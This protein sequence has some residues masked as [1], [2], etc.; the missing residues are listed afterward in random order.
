MYF[1]DLHNDTHIWGCHKTDWQGVLDSPSLLNAEEQKKS[2]HYLY[3]DDQK[4]YRIGRHLLRSKAAEYL[5]T[6]ARKIVICNDNNGK[7]Y[8][9]DF[10]DVFFSLS[11][12]G[13]WVMVAISKRRIGIDVQEHYITDI[14]KI[15]NISRHCLHDDEIDYLSKL[16]DHMFINKF[17]EAWCIK[18]SYIK[19]YGNLSIEDAKKIS[20][21]NLLK[22]KDKIRLFSIEN[23]YT[24]AIAVL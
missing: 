15:K 14:N 7:P 22:N 9:K 23:N 21:L 24:A 1:Q 4:R 8:F 3:A 19:L 18:E 5:A 20:S 6:D 13:D 16:P 10:G 2:Y 11:H 12:S 17:Y